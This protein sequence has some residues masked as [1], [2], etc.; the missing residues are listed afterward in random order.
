VSAYEDLP[1]GNRRVCELLEAAGINPYWV[2]FGEVYEEGYYLVVWNGE[3]YDEVPPPV[4]IEATDKIAMTFHRWEI[5]AELVAEI[6]DAVRKTP[7]S[8]TNN[9]RGML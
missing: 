9:E 1:P 3:P 5:P 6:V 2:P 8:A 4:V 7:W